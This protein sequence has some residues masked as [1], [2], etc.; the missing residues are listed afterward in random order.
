MYKFVEG[1][2]EGIESKMNQWSLSEAYT[3]QPKAVHVNEEDN[4]LKCN[5]WDGRLHLIWQ[6]QHVI[7]I[8]E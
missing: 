8:S 4:A 3:C 2:R 7:Y 1:D 6:C 5:M